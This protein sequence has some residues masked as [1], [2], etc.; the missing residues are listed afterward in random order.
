MEEIFQ[1]LRS[2]NQNNACKI[3]SGLTAAA[4]PATHSPVTPLRLTF[5][6]LLMCNEGMTQRETKA[7]ALLPPLTPTSK[8]VNNTIPFSADEWRGNPIK[9]GS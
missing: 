4:G 5:F 3:R 9:E 6:L 1:T 2:R 7:A 8:S